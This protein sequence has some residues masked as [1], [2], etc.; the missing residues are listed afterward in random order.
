MKITAE[1]A[2]QLSTLPVEEE[3]DLVFNLIREA[4]G[5]KQ[6]SIRVSHSDMWKTG[7]YIGSQEW[8]MIR[9]LFREAGFEIKYCFDDYRESVGYT[10]ISW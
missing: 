2:R 5:N 8:L 9:E 7:G 1:E 10:M 6:R 3:V 4:A